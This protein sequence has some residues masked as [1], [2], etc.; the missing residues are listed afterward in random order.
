MFSKRELKV[1]YALAVCLLVVGIICYA[2]YSA[3]PPDPPIRLMFDVTTGNVLFDHQTHTSVMG[4]GIS[5][6]DCHHT[7]EE[8]EYDSAESCSECH[9]PDE[10]DEEV[11][12]RGDAFHLQCI[13]CHEDFGA[14]PTECS[15]CHIMS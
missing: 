7:L 15:E 1:A 5:C 3:K 13:G 8:D 4:Y 12:K 9:A 14:G 6:G 2:A 10:G 11:P